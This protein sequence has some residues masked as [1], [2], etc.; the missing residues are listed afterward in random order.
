MVEKPENGRDSMQLCELK[1]FAG[2]RTKIKVPASFIRSWLT[3]GRRGFKSTITGAELKLHL[4]DYLGDII[5]SSEKVNLQPFLSTLFGGILDNIGQRKISV[6]YNALV[7]LPVDPPIN[8]EV[9][10]LF[11]KKCRVLQKL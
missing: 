2:L 4:V 11:H 7:N 9:I 10:I 6:F 5:N 8:V 1:N 3:T